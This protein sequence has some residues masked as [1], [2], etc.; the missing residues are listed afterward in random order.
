LPLDTIEV[1]KLAAAIGNQFDLKTLSIISETSQA[2]TL[3]HLWP[4]INEGLILPM[5]DNYKWVQEQEQK[6]AFFRFLHDRVQQAAYALIDDSKKKTVHLSIGRLLLNNTSLE[7]EPEKLFKILDHLNMARSLILEPQQLLELAQLNLMAGIKAKQATAYAASL[8]YLVIGMSCLSE[9]AWEDNYDLALALH[10][11]RAGLEFLNGHFEESERLIHQTVERVKTPLEKAEVLHILIVQYT[12]SARY[13]K[14]IETGRQALAL[15][16]IDLADDNFEQVRDQEMLEIKAMIGDRTIASLFELPIMT[17][18]IYMMAVKLLITMGPPC[19][20]SHQR[21]WGVIVAKVVHLTLQYGHVPQIGYSHTAYGGLLGYVWQDYTTGKELGK[22]ATRLMT[23][24]LTDSSA[25]QSVF[26]LMIGSSVRHWYEPLQ[27]ATQDYQKAYHIG[28]ESGNLQYAVYAFG[29]NMYCR[30]YQGVNLLELFTEIDG[31]LSFCRSRKNQWGI[32]LME[33]GQLVILNLMGE[34]ERTASTE[35]GK[36]E[37]TEAQFVE[38][39]EAHRNIQVLCIFYILKTQALYLHGHFEQALDSAKEAEKRIISVATQGLLPASEHRFT[40]S[41]LLLALYPQVSPVQQRDYWK[42]IT[43]NQRLAQIWVD[44][45][46]ANFQHQYLL[47]AAEMARLSGHAL[48]AMDLYDQAIASAQQ[49]GFIQNEALGN[50]LAAN[51]WLGKGKE[52]F[53]KLYLKEAYYNYQLWGAK[54]KTADLEEEYP[55]LFSKSGFPQ[56]PS[57]MAT[58][59][60]NATVMVSSA[61]RRI[62]SST[63]LDLESVMKA[64]Q[65]LSGEMVLSRLLSKMMTIVIENAGADRGCLLLPQQDNWFIEAEGQ[66]NSSDITILQSMAIENRVSTHIIHYIA[67]TQENVVLSD[68]TQEERFSQD[69]YIVKQAPKSILGMPLVNQGKLTGILYLENRLTEGA[70]TPQRLQILNMLSSQLAI[71]IE[72]SLLYNNLEQKVAERTQALQQEI[73]ERKRAEEAAKV[74]NQAKSEFLSN[75]SHELRT[76]LNGVLGYAQIL[77]RGRNLDSSQL[78]GINT[79]Y[80]S[81]NHLLML[82]NDILDLSKIEAQKLELYP[83]SIHFAGF[84][85]SITG[86]IRMR[87]E[88]KDVYFAYEPRGDLPTG[89][90]ADEKRLRQV[91]INLLGNAV[92]FTDQG[93]VTLRVSVVKETQA[94]NAEPLTVTLLF[95]V[96]DTGVGMTPEQLGK[97]FQPFEQVGDTQK[98]LE[99]TGLGLAI[100]RQLVELMGSQIQ[101]KTEVGK[102]STFGFEIT[103]PIVDVKAQQEDQT[104]QCITGYQGERQTVLV[105]DDKPENR[106]ILVNMLEHVGFNVVEAGN[107]QEAVA[108]AKEVKPKVILMD[109]VMPIMTGFEA[110]QAIRQLPEFQKTLIIANSAS[111]FEADQEKSRVIGCDEFLAK[112]IEETQ[113]LNILANRLKL[114]WIYQTVEEETMPENSV[115]ENAPLVPPPLENLEALY[116]L[117]M[118]G[119][120]LKVREQAAQIEALDEKYIPFARQIEK[121][122]KDF[123]EEQ[124]VALVEPHLK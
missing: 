88:Q 79:I 41:F 74:A 3:T 115:A 122:A 123:D 42:K 27:H 61:T 81:G 116:E 99:G 87:A 94:K 15:L 65:T 28:L 51:F 66:V 60:K 96:E 121:L 101:V 17:D 64:S 54:R 44:N 58:L 13:P 76:P 53:A 106:V 50:E 31:Y 113:L 18:P 7:T 6:L 57:T 100:S 35:F 26:Y 78:T 69:P 102:G 11:E 82:I 89:I 22:L 110:V 9:Q 84:I 120:M 118:M 59:N 103:F 72:N 119:K 52:A 34:S 93:R 104:M 124:I 107:G 46:P 77:R 71:S 45:C 36:K 83:N 25:A 109:L 67:R 23:E 114:E 75:M 98:R 49:N 38:R 21:L 12:L 56:T 73:V 68:A 111:V 32:D 14:A 47:I 2:N 1:I 117:A 62:S 37:L 24:K 48:E 80:Q 63:A 91:L 112:P 8:Q 108:I 10:K 55:E 16:G 43:A 40:E 20:R 105:V 92:K 90:E 85:E 39:C 19:Y 86:I 4:A 29:H 70:F 5:D 33:A 30:F 97:I 95:E